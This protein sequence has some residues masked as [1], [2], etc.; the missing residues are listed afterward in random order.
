[1]EYRGQRKI[2]KFYILEKTVAP[3][4]NWQGNNNEFRKILSRN[5]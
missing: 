2:V 5:V 3:F 4:I 1:M